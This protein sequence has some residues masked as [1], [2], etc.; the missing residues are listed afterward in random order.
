MK[1][2]VRSTLATLLVGVFGQRVLQLLSFLCI[3]RALGAERLGTYA[4]GTAVAALVAVLAGQGVRSVMARAVARCPGAAA[5]LLWTSVRTRLGVGAALSVAG[6]GVAFATT[7]APWFWTLCV[8]QVL[9]AAFDLKNLL[10]VAGR[11][12]REVA[13]ETGTALLQLVLVLAWLALGGHD[14]TTVAAIGLGSRTAY[15]LLALPAIRG[16]ERGAAVAADAVPRTAPGLGLAA[17]QG[18]HSILCAGDIWFVALC[19]GDEAAGFYAVATRFA[20][21]ALLPS[22]QLARL[23]MPHM[24]HAGAGG[25]PR[26]TLAKASRATLLV[27]LPMLAGGAVTAVGLCTLPG[28]AFAAA[29]P[30]LVLALLAG[31]LQHAGWQQSNALLAAGRDRAYGWTFAGPAVL[32]AGLFVA[33]GALA[34][35]LDL[36]P[37]DAAL[38]GAGLAVVAH[39]VYCLATGW[40]VRDLRAGHA[41]PFAGVLRTSLA[42][43]LAAALPALLGP[44]PAV[45]PLQLTAGGITFAAWLWWLE[46]RGRLRRFGDGLAAASGFRA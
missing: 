17:A 32:H 42:T 7:E 15:A 24:L 22:T 34:P 27:T 43:G 8:L 36:T 26:R 6:A 38:C 9:P 35:T 3:G 20:G 21:A 28:A 11:T 4:Q 12:R 25:D 14:L 29:A 40:A 41:L 46:L 39:G 31:C 33:F 19:F 18:L 23:L 2:A 10:D 13:L 30:A 45:L 1:H 5:D 44:G 16:L 37:P